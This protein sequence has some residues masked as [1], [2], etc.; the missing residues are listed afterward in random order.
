MVEGLVSAAG[1]L[2]SERGRIGGK[3]GGRKPSKP[4]IIVLVE[5]REIAFV[6]HGEGVE[7]LRMVWKQEVQSIDFL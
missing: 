4:I 2:G 7:K 1:M 5:E 6:C 3:R